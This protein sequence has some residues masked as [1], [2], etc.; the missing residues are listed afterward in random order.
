MRVILSVTEHTTDPRI[1][2]RNLNLPGDDQ[3][4]TVQVSHPN[5]DE[6]DLERHH[7]CTKE[8]GAGHASY[9]GIDTR[10]VQPGADE[11][12]DLKIAILNEALID[13][14]IGRYQ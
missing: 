7:R 8:A 14:G 10:N 6:K 2:T 12:Y 3:P 4:R 13:L 5:R 1:A 9:R 11:I